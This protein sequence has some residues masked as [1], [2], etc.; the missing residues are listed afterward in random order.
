LYKLIENIEDSI[1]VYKAIETLKT[2]ITNKH[3]TKTIFFKDAT[4]S[5]LQ[6]LLKLLGNKDENSMKYCNFTD[7]EN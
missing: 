5:V 6:H 1:I 2:L 4:A 7:S 3:I